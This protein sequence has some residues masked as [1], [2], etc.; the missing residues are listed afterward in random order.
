MRA[1]DRSERR[2]KGRRR[3]V[4]AV[5]SAGASIL[6][7]EAFLRSNGHRAEFLEEHAFFHAE[8][9]SQGL[10]A[11]HSDPSLRY[12]LA[13][14]LDLELSDRRYRTSSRGTRGDEVDA[15]KEPGERRLLYLGGERIFGLHSSEGETLPA[16]LAEL[17]KGAERGQ[18]AKKPGAP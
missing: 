15:E 14:G 5:L 4:A 3:F 16:H 10:L 13:P 9:F 17:A 12:V 11:A 18:R 8:L 2:T 6:V 1:L 7:A